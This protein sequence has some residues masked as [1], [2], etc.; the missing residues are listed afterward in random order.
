MWNN[1][2]NERLAAWRKFR[3]MQSLL[4]LDE[5]VKN[6]IKLWKDCHLGTTHYDFSNINDW[7]TPWELIMEDSFDG[8]T[9][10]LGIAWTL[11]MT[12]GWEN[13]EIK[14][15]CYIDIEKSSH[16]FLV[17]INDDL[18]LNYHFD[19][20]I[21]RSTIPTGARLLCEYNFIDLLSKTK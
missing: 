10:A 4:P 8:F 16:Y 1:R 18:I 5:Q 12:D 14:L 9:R 21:S 19:K 17:E 11:I 6:A 15:R 3:Y 2:G 7:P 13:K 20:P